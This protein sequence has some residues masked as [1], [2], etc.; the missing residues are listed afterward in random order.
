HDS[1]DARRPHHRPATDCG[2]TLRVA[3]RMHGHRRAIHAGEDG[4]VDRVQIVHI[5]ID[6]CQPIFA[7]HPARSNAPLRGT[8]AQ[9]EP[10]Q[11]L[12]R[13]EVAVPIIEHAQ[14]FEEATR[15][16]RVPMADEPHLTGSRPRRAQRVI[17]HGSLRPNAMFI[18]VQVTRIVTISWGSAVKRTVFP[19]PSSTN[20]TDSRSSAR[21]RWALFTPSPNR[22]APAALRSVAL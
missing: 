15:E 12:R 11:S 21:T 4:G 3:E 6:L 16:L 14:L 18:H 20:A 19:R 10:R 2:R 8:L 13:H 17:A 5:V 22:Q 9:V 7:R 1:I